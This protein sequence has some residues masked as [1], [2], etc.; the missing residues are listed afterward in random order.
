MMKSAELYDFAENRDIILIDGCLKKVKSMSLSDNGMCA[1][2]I[3]NEKINSEVEE[4]VIAAHE[5]GHCETG[6]FYNEHSL[7]LRSRMEYRADKWAI[8]K[9]VPEDELIEVF[10][11]G[12]T[13]IWKLAEHFG[14]TEDFMIKVCEYYGYYHKAI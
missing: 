12:I 11:S 10:E 2:V 14:V 8:K 1:I 7:E 3:D 5:L 4:T 13:E 9:L 6:A